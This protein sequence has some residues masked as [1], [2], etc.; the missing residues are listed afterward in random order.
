[1]AG[2]R[3][4][5]AVAGMGLNVNW[6]RGHHAFGHRVGRDVLVDLAGGPI[7]RVRLLGAL[8]DALEAEIGLLESGTSTWEVPAR[9]RGSPGV[10]SRSRHRPVAL[11]GWPMRIADNGGLILDGPVVQTTVNVG[12]VI[13]VHAGA[14]AT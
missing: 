9:H 5:S 3:V 4:I 10:R 6:L 2:D 13:A 8:L 1:M 11:L 7:D 12:E 14:A